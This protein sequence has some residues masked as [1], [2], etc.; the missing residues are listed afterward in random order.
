AEAF[1]NNESEQRGPR[2]WLVVKTGE[3]LKHWLHRIPATRCSNE[4]SCETGDPRLPRGRGRARSDLRPT[5]FVTGVFPRSIRG[6]SLEAQR[7]DPS[8]KVTTPGRGRRRT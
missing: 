3:R 1:R 4:Q 5:T 6:H 8:A 2:R 7:A